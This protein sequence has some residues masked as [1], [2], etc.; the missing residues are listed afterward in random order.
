[1]II[2]INCPFWV[3]RHLLIEAICGN[4]WFVAVHVANVIRLSVND[5]FMCYISPADD[6]NLARF[7]GNNSFLFHLLRRF[8]IVVTCL[9]TSTLPGET[10]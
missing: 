6:P 8:L 5:L 9:I 4:E 3:W 7:S 1:M 10:A 2:I